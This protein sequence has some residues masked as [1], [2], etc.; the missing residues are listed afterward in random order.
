[1]FTLPEYVKRLRDDLRQKVIAHE[2]VKRAHLSQKKKSENLEDENKRLKKENNYLKKENE[3][4]KQE[5]EKLTKTNE[6]YRVAL[7]DHGNFKNPETKDK[8]KKGGQ[9]GHAD[10]NNDRKRNYQSFSRKRIFAN[11]CGECGN[12]LKRTIGF[13]EKILIDIQIN[14]QIIQNI[15]E[16]EKQWCKKCHKEI[17]A[18]HDQ[19]LPFT[20]FGINTFMVIMH[21]R[22]KGKQS[23]RTI[24]VTLN[25]LFGLSIT[26]PGILNLLF[27]AKEYLDEKYED[28]KRAVRNGDVMVNA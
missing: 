13:K 27:Q 5:I 19:S 7:F 2:T 8:K 25:S 18:A 14:T 28:L 23:I 22:F 12:S 15:I 16:S 26:K 21:L 4:L 11:A 9:K 17:R 20:E 24:A 1:M 6:R 10:T 3:E